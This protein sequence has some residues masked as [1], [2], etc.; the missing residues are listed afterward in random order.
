VNEDGRD[1]PRP[2]EKRHKIAIR[3]SVDL[4]TALL[5]EVEKG[6]EELEGVKSGLDGVAAGNAYRPGT[7]GSGRNYEQRRSALYEGSWGKPRGI[8]LEHLIATEQ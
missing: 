7:L 8:R 6:G 3:F 1:F 2:P 4:A 5:M